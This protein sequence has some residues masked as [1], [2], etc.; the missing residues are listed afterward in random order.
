[1][2][3]PFH[4]DSS[5]N[6]DSPEKLE[7]ATRG[8]FVERC[9]FHLSLPSTNDYCIQLAKSHLNEVRDSRL[10]TKFPVT[11]VLAA[12]Q[13]AGRGR[14][15]ARWHSSSG[16]L[17]FSLVLNSKSF[18]YSPR[19]QSRLSLITSLAVAKSIERLPIHE[20]V[21]CKWPNDVVVKSAKI[22]GVLVEVPAATLMV[23]GVGINVN[24]SVASEING[25]EYPVT[26]VVDLVGHAVVSCELLAD[27]L[28][29]FGGLAE[30]AARDASQLVT[31]WNRYDGLAGQA[32]EIRHASSTE[33]GIANGINEDGHLLFQRKDGGS[34][35]SIAS[36]TVR[37]I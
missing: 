18:G 9:E 19:D 3:H 7:F 1:M 23:I 34:V 16:S 6:I 11:L 13:T 17:T 26:S 4:D 5:P 33:T 36:G 29:H 27:F 2:S 35:L 8:T 28:R 24:D 10:N 21:Q 25:D 32:I 22:A 31:A 12:N 30:P 15:S 20:K 37:R 14:N